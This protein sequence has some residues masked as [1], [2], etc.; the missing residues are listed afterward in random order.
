MESEWVRLFRCPECKSKKLILSHTPAQAEVELGGPRI[1]CEACGHLVPIRNGIPRFVPESN[2]ANS[3]GFQW[4]RH[5]RTQLDSYS[6][7]P[8]SRSRLFSVTQWKEDLQGERILEAGSGAGRFT[9]ILLQTGASV[10]SFDYSNAVDANF[11][12]NR[13]SANLT[14]FQGDIYNIPILPGSFDKVICLG[15]L[16]HTP[17]PARAFLSLATM[18][19]P[20]GELVIDVYANTVIARMQWYYLLRPITRRMEKDMLYRFIAKWAPRLIPVARVLRAVAGRAGARLV[21]IAEY[22]HL[23]LSPEINRE[24]AVLDTFDMYSPAHD[25]P[26]SMSAVQ[27]WFETA[28]F[29]EIAVRRGPNG[30][31]GKGRKI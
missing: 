15:V 20:G 1:A 21:P 14:L 3:F 30:V 23:G 17:E 31:I 9:E 25:H 13:Q 7:V 26:Q 2:Y 8:I 4:N 28:G 24:W 12:N 27:R 22:S 5:R 16:Q 19:R 6:G 10:Y 18:V 29:S 11:E